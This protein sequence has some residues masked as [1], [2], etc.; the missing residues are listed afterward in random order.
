LARF[1][2]VG[3]KKVKPERTNRGFIPCLIIL[4][5]GFLLLTLLMFGVFKTG[6]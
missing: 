5:L 6:K 1:K 2:P 3:S 4:G